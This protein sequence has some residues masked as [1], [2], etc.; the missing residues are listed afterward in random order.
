M[1]P[2]SGNKGTGK[3]N[4]AAA[5]IQ[6]QSRNTTPAPAPSSTLPPQENYDPDYLNTRVITFA[7]LGFDDI[8][9]QAASNAPVPESRSV[10]AMLEK[11][12]SLSEIMEKRSTFYD[13]GMR[14]LA[15]ERKNRPDV[16]DDSEP[17]KSK[18]KRKKG[19]DKGNDEKSSPVRDPKRKSTGE[20]DSVSSSLSPVAG[21]SPSAMEVDEKK[22]KDD[23]EE[24]E[25]SSEDEGAPPR[26]EMP[27]AQTF[28]DDPSTFPDPTVYEIRDV[29][30]GMSEAEKKE[31]YSVATYPK[32]D[33]SDL[34]AGDPPDMDFS[35]AKPNSQINF[36]TFS[37]YIEPYFRAFAEEDLTFLRER[38]DRVSPFVMPRRGKRHYTEVW[39]E[40]DGAMSVDSPQQGR[41]KLPANQPRGSIENMSDAVGETDTLSLGPIAAR[42]LQMLRPENRKS[43]SDDKPVTN[44][45]TNG[46][47]SM[48]GDIKEEENI[49]AEDKMLPPATQMPESN[50]E[51]WKK[52]THPKLDYAQCDERMKSELKHIGFLPQDAEPDYD[53]H[54][55]D[56]IAARLRYLQDQ[57]RQ[58]M[59]INGARKARLTELVKERL[60]QQEY[61]TILEDLDSQVQA[62]YLKRTRTMGKSKK[63]KRP[64]G[65]GG[66]SHFVGGA[67]AGMARPGIG[68]QTKTLM[69][70]RRRWISEISPIFETDRYKVPRTEDPN[71][72]IFAA[73]TMAEYMK[74]EKQQWDEE[75]EDE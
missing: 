69:D 71:S 4:A 68:D 60:A 38:G 30:P 58:T 70:R 21:A 66:G 37:T 5:N 57:L 73:E 55:D 65:A 64:G 36:S 49:N 24:E 14:F 74:R 54:F 41:D 18:H 43:P 67:G 1:A 6:K 17:K 23:D 47:I 8:V 31:I 32:D 59:L 45:T 19:G 62:A 39:A 3:K 56:E 35:S 29:K 16:Y 26:R 72:T 42:L 28:G 75:V 9:D 10:N 40:E 44:G 12:K 53:G 50:T 34:I 33:L 22:K 2:A 15:D 51:A 63:A 20:N 7:N 61:Q 52:S 46:D 13:R 11:L 25:S 27:Q 48:N